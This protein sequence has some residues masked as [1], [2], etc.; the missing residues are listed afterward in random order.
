[1]QIVT[2]NGPYPIS[3]TH[4]I[5]TLPLHSLSSLVPSLSIPPLPYSTVHV[6]NLLFPETSTP[7]HPPGFGYLVPRPSTDYPSEGSTTPEQAI[8]GT[9]FDSSI[10]QTQSKFTQMTLMLGGPY[11]LSPTSLASFSLSSI[12]Q[13]LRTQL[14]LRRPLPD[15]ILHRLTTH[16]SCIPTYPVNHLQRMVQFRDELTKMG[17]WLDVAGA[18]TG[19]GVGVGDCVESGRKAALRISM[20][21]D[22]H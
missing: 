10:S 14:S 18:G 16:K 15:P 3:A 20:R 13:T 7:L 6:L 8:L 12:L 19:E 22:G 21:T 11:Q 4:I 17:G 5:S 1:M 9:I 2:S